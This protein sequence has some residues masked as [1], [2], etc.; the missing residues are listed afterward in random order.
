MMSL[1]QCVRLT[2]TFL[3][4]QILMSA[5]KREMA[6]STFAEI[7]LAPI[8]V[9]VEMDIICIK[10]GNLAWVGMLYS[11]KSLSTFRAVIILGNVL[12]Y[13]LSLR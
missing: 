8:I 7:Q 6:V 4:V 9:C 13:I 1:I 5:Q 12:L 2:V 11:V 3:C 10:M